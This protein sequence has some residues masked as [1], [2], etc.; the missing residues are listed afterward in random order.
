MVNCLVW[1]VEWHIYRTW[2]H[3][4]RPS[5][6]C[7]ICQECGYAWS[8]S[9]QVFHPTLDCGLCRRSSS[10]RPDWQAAEIFLQRWI[11]WLDAPGERRLVSVVGYEEEVE[12]SADAVES[13]DTDRW[14]DHTVTPL[15]HAPTYFIAICSLSSNY[16]LWPPCIADADI[17]VLSCFFFFFFSLPNL[18][19]HRLDVYHT[20]T[21][22]MAL[23][24]I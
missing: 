15:W 12:W 17:I 11:L 23:V 21:H 4:I 6:L 3:T 9:F 1:I 8:R 19:G 2:L 14:T 5:Y 16:S 22:G 13:R 24:Q 7:C 20:S 10:V 18:S